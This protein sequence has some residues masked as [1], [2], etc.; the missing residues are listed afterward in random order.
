M[1]RRRMTRRPTRRSARGDAFRHARFDPFERRFEPL[2]TLIDLGET[3]VEG[4]PEEGVFLASVDPA[5]VAK[6]RT[7]FPALDDRRPSAYKR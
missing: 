6:L 5:A 7:R 3:L 2:E 4:G 1:P